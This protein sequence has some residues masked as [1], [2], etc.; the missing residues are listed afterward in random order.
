MLLGPMTRQHVIGKIDPTSVRLGPIYPY[1]HD[2]VVHE[3]REQN[4]NWQRDT[5]QPQK[6]SSSETHGNLQ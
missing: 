3:Q 6:R 4:D 5:E 1:Y 2:L